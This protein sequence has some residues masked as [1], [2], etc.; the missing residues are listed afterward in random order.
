MPE[1]EGGH[2]VYKMTP[3][4]MAKAL[5]GFLSEYNKVRIIGG[6]LWYKSSTS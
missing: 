3:N 6:W 5:D 2:A 1:N 4:D